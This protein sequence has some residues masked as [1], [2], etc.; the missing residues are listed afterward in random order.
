[1]FQLI[2]DAQLR[3]VLCQAGK[4]HHLKSSARNETPLKRDADPK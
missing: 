4:V 3:I 2:G 1:M